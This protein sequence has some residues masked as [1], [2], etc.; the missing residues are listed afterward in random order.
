[1]DPERKVKTCPRCKDTKPVEGGF[2]MRGALPMGY[3][4]VCQREVVNDR[5]RLIRAENRRRAD[6]LK[7]QPC[8]DCGRS[9]EPCAMDFDHRDPTTKRFDVATAVGGGM[10]WSRIEA[11]IQKCDLVCAV[12]HRYRTAGLHG[13]MV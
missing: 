1:M 9:F 13:R 3:C 12:C 5:K 2:H 8:M 10:V 11:E 6:A 7:R 4:K